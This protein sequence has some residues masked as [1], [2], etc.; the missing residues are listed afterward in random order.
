MTNLVAFQFESQSITAACEA[1]PCLRLW[2]AVVQDAVRDS[3]A[4]V[5][6][7]SV[8]CWFLDNRTHACSFI[9]VAGWLDLNV[10]AVRAALQ[11]RWA[12][13]DAARRARVASVK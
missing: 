12:R 10:D 3:C 5:G 1:D 9:W 6:Y 8:R 7:E 11:A 4:A 2:A 13:C